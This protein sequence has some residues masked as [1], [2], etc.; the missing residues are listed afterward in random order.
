MPNKY[1][2]TSYNVC[3]TKLLRNSTVVGVLHDFLPESYFFINSNAFY[4]VITSYS[5]HYTKLYDEIPNIILFPAQFVGTDDI[6]QS[7]EFTLNS[8]AY[9][10]DTYLP[11][12]ASE[13][14]SYN[15]V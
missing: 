11:A 8:A 6:V 14:V 5:I 9:K 13:I 4:Y 15:F 1:R 10:L 7:T 2:I 12:T 3:Y